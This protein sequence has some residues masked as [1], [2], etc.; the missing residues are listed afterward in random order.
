M[1]RRASLEGKWTPLQRGQ[2]P[3][4]MASVSKRRDYARFAITI[5]ASLVLATAAFLVDIASPASMWHDGE[6]QLLPIASATGVDYLSL[7][8]EGS[9]VYAMQPTLYSPARLNL[10]PSTLTLS[11]YP[12]VGGGATELVFTVTYAGDMRQVWGTEQGPAEP[13]VVR[14]DVTGS[15]HRDLYRVT[16]ITSNIGTASPD[17]FEPYDHESETVRAE[18]GGTYTVRAMV[19]FVAEGF[20]SVYAFGFDADIVTVSVATSKLVSMP[21]SEYVATQQNYLDSIT[22]TLTP[23]PVHTGGMLVPEKR[24]VADLSARYFAESNMWQ[25]FNATGTVMTE[26]WNYT[27]FMPVHGIEVCVY[28]GSSSPHTLLYTAV[29]DPACDYTDTSGQY[30]IHNVNWVNPNNMTTPDT[31]VVVQSR[32]YGGAIDL[33]WHDRAN[34]VSYAYNATSDVRTDYPGPILVRN[35][36]FSDADPVTIS[37]VTTN[38]VLRSPAN[39]GMAGAA[40]IISAISDGMA[41]FKE[42]GQNP[43]S[44]NVMWNHMN[45]TRIYTNNSNMDGAYY[46]ATISTIY[47]DG[48][49][50][51][52]D[53]YNFWVYD[54]SR[55]RHTIFHEYGHHVHGV[56][57]PAGLNYNCNV[58]YIPEKYDERCAWG[59]GWANL[60]PHLIDG[61]VEMPRGMRGERINI[62]TGHS[63]SLGELPVPFKT[64]EAS[65]R[66]VGEKV[67]GSVAAAMWDMADDVVDPVHDMSPPK[68]AGSDNVSAGVDDLLSVFFAGSYDNFANFYDRWEIDMRHNSAEDIAILHGMAFSIPSNMSYY[69]FAG[70][71]DGVFKYGISG[72]VF[73]SNYVDVSNDG[74]TVAVTS[75]FGQ[76]LQIV[77][78]WAGE[79]KGLHASYGYSH[80][81]TLKE[82]P[83]TCLD[84]STARE[85]EDLK[86]G[87]FSYMNAI[88]F[89]RNSSL[90]L[91]SDD[92]QN[93]IQALGLDGT[94][95]GRFGTSGN[96]NGEFSTPNGIAFLLGDAVAAVSDTGNRRIQ[97][98]D[99]A[100]DGSAQY[101]GQFESYTEPQ[102]RPYFTPQQLATGPGGALYAAGF[103]IPSIWVYPSPHDTSEVMRI[104]DPSL[105]NLGGIAVDPDGLVYVSD[106][107]QGKIRVYD[108]NN[109]RGVVNES[110]TQLDGRML[111]VRTVQAD[112]SS[113]DVNDAEAFIDEF[114]SLG[115]Y[116]W[117]FGMPLGVA[118]GPSNKSTG[119][120]RVYVADGLRG[121]KM[122]EKDREVPRIE[123]VWAHT[124]DGTVTLGDTVEIAVNFS[125]RVTVTGHTR[126]CTRNGCGG[127]E[128][129]V[130]VRI[131]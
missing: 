15:G 87:E 10:H 46:D 13:P 74:S 90:M 39:E 109:L 116:P 95:L 85:E 67:E 7:E 27:R 40:R 79:H 28:D 8:K 120:M 77:D 107:A 34:N 100:G 32:G 29:A 98:F 50:P 129:G 47:L 43:A 119:D 104:D 69:E 96:G 9:T 25:T 71:L 123:S 11:E 84:N 99:I 118:L 3:A 16:N 121:V 17:I 76:G 86:P 66:P 1:T 78:A 88:A 2:A 6:A 103:S 51:Y 83:F 101:T 110:R 92:Y 37:G 108:P 75:R 93:H 122:Y 53:T 65:G 113:C 23:N 31:L 81:C 14:L 56:H 62:E 106:W 130:R 127:V 60:V 115:G 114:G 41:F 12:V 63:I 36:N 18:L 55:N 38:L 59:E 97:M 33:K 82:D 26:N 19:E 24:R 126:S 21:Y 70:E 68:P 131:G 57:D 20:I 52:D 89:G 44:L 124:P 117:Q 22:T 105:C 73:S 54:D 35:F 80:A 91:V 72:L 111:T 61:I 42:R 30:E 4:A 48:A 102:K 5:A 64:F 94:P 58:H 128:C 125:E 45:G 49:L 112:T